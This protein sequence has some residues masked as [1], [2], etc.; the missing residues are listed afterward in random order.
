MNQ[1][2]TPHVLVV[3]DD[4][5]QRRLLKAAVEHMGAV[6]HLAE[7]GDTALD[8]L[9]AGEA[10]FSIVVQLPAFSRASCH[11]LRLILR[12]FQVQWK[13][14]DFGMMRSARGWPAHLGCGC[15]EPRQL[16]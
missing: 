15:G 10:P 16:P 8:M 4:P 14:R 5:V 11:G 2:A 7:D 3:D 12:H 9:D 13:S 1:T 6:P